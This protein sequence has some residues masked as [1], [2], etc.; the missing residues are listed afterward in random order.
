MTPTH[1]NDPRNPSGDPLDEVLRSW[2]PTSPH[3]NEKIVSDCMRSI[4][5][6]NHPKSFGFSQFI[7]KFVRTWLP[8]PSLLVP[9]ATLIVVMI[10]GYQAQ[11]FFE[12]RR[13][14]LALQAKQQ[15]PNPLN[16]TTLAGIVA[17]IERR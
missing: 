13:Q 4:R 1:Q 15:L 16:E 17:K 7:E 6:T 10:T 9:V 2:N 11:S 3:S 8:E 5:S 14:T 12:Q